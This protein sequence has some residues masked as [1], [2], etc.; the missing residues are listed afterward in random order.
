MIELMAGDIIVPRLSG[1]GAPKSTCAGCGEKVEPYSNWSDDDG[2][3]CVLDC[4]KIFAQRLVKL[5][6]KLT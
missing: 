6:K 1:P 3:H 4:L 5:E 2:R